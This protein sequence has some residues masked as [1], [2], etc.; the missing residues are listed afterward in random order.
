MEYIMSLKE[1]LQKIVNDQEEILLNDGT[2]EWE[3][4]MLLT[5][6]PEPRLRVNAYFQSG[7]YIAEVDPKGY[8]GK[9]LYRVKTKN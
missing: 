9:V 8:L 4:D 2:K 7:L 1:I 5:S 3:A 6:L